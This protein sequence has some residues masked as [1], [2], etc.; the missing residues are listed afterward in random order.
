MTHPASTHPAAQR[1]MTALIRAWI[2]WPMTS[3]FL[4]T[5]GTVGVLL[6]AFLVTE[7]RDATRGRRG[8]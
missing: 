2:P 6:V 8:R 5:S 4:F 7:V 3:M 1:A